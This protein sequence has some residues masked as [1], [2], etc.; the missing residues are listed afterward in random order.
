MA[1]L[2]TPAKKY[3]T[4]AETAQLLSVN[5]SKIRFW[6]KQVGLLKPRRNETGSRTYTQADLGRLKEICRLIQKGYTLKGV[7]QA[8]NQ[9]IAAPAHRQSVLEG[10]REVKN[11]LATLRQAPSETD[12][13]TRSEQS[14]ASLQATPGDVQ[15][16]KSNS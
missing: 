7:K 11:F 6:E 1:D 5:A 14:N 9:R 16:T 3:Y 2:E 10:L 4:I 8:I 12:V 13:D 15:V